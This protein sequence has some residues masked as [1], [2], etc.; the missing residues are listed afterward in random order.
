MRQP[1][2]KHHQEQGPLY[3]WRHV[4]ISLD[5]VYDDYLSWRLPPRN[6]V[7][8]ILF[9]WNYPLPQDSPSN[10]QRQ[11]DVPLLALQLIN[12][13]QSSIVP[14]LFTVL[15]G[16][17]FLSSQF[18]H[19]SHGKLWRTGTEY[20]NWDLICFTKSTVGQLF[21]ETKAQ[22]STFCSLSLQNCPSQT[23]VQ[24]SGQSELP[25]ICCMSCCILY[26][27]CRC[28]CVCVCEVEWTCFWFVFV[29]VQFYPIY[30]G[31]VF[32]PFGILK[33]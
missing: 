19:I 12:F 11:N 6:F 15:H 20:G 22:A 30:F 32:R 27:S 29:P 10:G 24:D 16:T 8:L 23:H 13:S 28:V 9:L 25:D 18:V 3:L 4:I 14:I 33:S 26:S 21:P 2:F 1:L 7:L 31:P 5:C 17:W